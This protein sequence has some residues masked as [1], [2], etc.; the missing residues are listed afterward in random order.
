MFILER[1]IL[2]SFVGPFVFSTSVITFVFIMDFIIRYIDLFLEKGVK[3][4]IVLQAFLLSLGHMFALIIPMAVLPTT[5]MSFG[6]L[7]AE[8]EI[9][10]MKA[11]GISL[12]RMILP[13]M[14]A[15]VL[16]TTGLVYYN[17][18]VLP[19]ANHALLNLLIAI[20]RKK[21]T[22]ELKANTRIDDF[23]GYTI[24]FREKNDK[25]GEIRDVQIV[26]H[27]AKGVYPTTINAESGRLVFLQA[28]NVL[29]FDL[30]NGEIHELPVRNDLTKYRYTKFEQYTINIKDVDRSLQQTDRKSRGDREMSVAMMR[31]KIG[32]I[33]ADIALANARIL[34]AAN[35]RMKAT[36][37]LLNADNRRSQFG[38]IEADST[39]GLSG[40]QNRPELAGKTRAA[41]ARA[42]N[43]E[44]QTAGIDGRNEYIARQ[45]IKTQINTK[46]SYYKQIDRYLVE[47][48]KK[49]SIPFACIIFVLI[50]SPIA[51]RMG[52]SGMS[53]AIGLSM[54]FFLV[55]YICLIGGEKIADRGL[56]SP[57]LAMW[58]PNIIFGVLAV[59]LLR[60]AARERSVSEWNIS[61]L[62]KLF[63]RN[64]VTNTR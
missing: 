54:L 12:Y 6:N 20:Q 5:L 21:P 33:H 1:Y 41:L 24:Y 56:V 59:I 48:H 37:S 29:Q 23:K 3:F 53:T 51:I 22:V 60:A 38:T 16:L 18:H 55:Y 8:N 40:R 9:T 19:D 44:A 42:R 52:K 36:F 45:E 11:G 28:E 4:H 14:L 43:R 57:L 13:G 27:A 64:A 17:S 49:Y 2:R 26:K 30:N 47:I 46:E 15:A 62:V 61:S 63:R 31:E 32:D 25:T 35:T 10:A 50:G 7:A 58:S 34:Q 39:T